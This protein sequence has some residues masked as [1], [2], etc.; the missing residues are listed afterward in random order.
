MLIQAFWYCRICPTLNPS[1]PTLQTWVKD[2]HHRYLR[3]FCEQKRSRCCNLSL[4][5]SI[6]C[7]PTRFACS[8][9][10]FFARCLQRV[11]ASLFRGP[12]GDAGGGVQGQQTRG[13]RACKRILHAWRTGTA[14]VSHVVFCLGFLKRNT[15]SPV[16]V[17]TV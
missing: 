16:F 9:A 17:T 15:F 7:S 5:C 4:A 11:D 13:E 8:F 6:A 3:N 10:R 2:Y 12:S 14:A 1:S